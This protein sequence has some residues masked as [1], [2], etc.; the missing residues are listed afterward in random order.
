MTEEEL[1]SG[2][3]PSGRRT[4]SS[5]AESV[6][7]LDTST[8]SVLVTLS[9]LL[10]LQVGDRARPLVVTRAQAPASPVAR[11]E[12]ATTPCVVEVP[13]RP[14]LFARATTPAHSSTW[15]ESAT[16]HCNPADLLH[17]LP[18]APALEEAIPGLLKTRQTAAH[19]VALGAHAQ[20][21]FGKRRGHDPPGLCPRGDCGW[22]RWCGYASL[23]TV[24]A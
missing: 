22:H 5:A 21:H 12:P 9:P 4:L 8:L 6:S 18:Q 14:L 13:T 24:R 16:T 19:H 20:T 23:S 11:A 3:P 10:T 2:E 1:S 7:R 15:A 17:H